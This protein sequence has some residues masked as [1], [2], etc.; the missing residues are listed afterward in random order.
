[1]Q[2]SDLQYVFTV[3]QTPA[4]VFGAIANV[5]GWWSEMLEG[6]SVKI[7]DEFIYRHGD[8]H[9]TRHRVTEA[10]PD[11]KIVWITLDSELTFVDKTDEWTGTKVIFEIS[12]QDD[13]T[14]LRFIHEGL[15]PELQCFSACSGGWNYYLTQSLLPLITTGNGK[16][17][18]N[19]D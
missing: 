17:D 9:Y 16:P 7:G 8:L 14:Q 15:T 4:E 10:I 5:R 2:N 1:M 3:D 6:N 13:K 11:A 19:N 12:K 18:K